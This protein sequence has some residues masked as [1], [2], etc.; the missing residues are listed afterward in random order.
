M[1]KD[2]DDQLIIVCLGPPYCA[3]QD[4]EA[5]QNQIDGCTMCRRIVVRSDGTEYEYQLKPH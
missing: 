1:R 3:L 4:D 5:V 2:D